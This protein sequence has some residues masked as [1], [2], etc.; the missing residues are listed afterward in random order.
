MRQLQREHHFIL[1]GFAK[2]I[3][4]ISK[5]RALTATW[6]GRPFLRFSARIPY[7]V[8]DPSANLDMCDMYFTLPHNRLG[9]WRGR[10]C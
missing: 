9:A 7:L 8:L 1:G 2:P 5:I 3:V 6:V 4:P 10:V